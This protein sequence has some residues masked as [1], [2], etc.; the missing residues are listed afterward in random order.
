MRDCSSKRLGKKKLFSSVSS[1]LKG[2]YMLE[3][4]D[5]VYGRQELTC[6]IDIRAVCFLEFIHIRQMELLRYV[7]LFFQV[8]LCV[9]SH[10]F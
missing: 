3:S 5:I 4:V 10:C 9:L 1:F 7:V 8:K 2:N 6:H